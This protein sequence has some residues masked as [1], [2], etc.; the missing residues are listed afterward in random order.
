MFFSLYLFVVSDW[1]S[2]VAW[3]VVLRVLFAIIHWVHE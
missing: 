1:V 2:Y 3:A